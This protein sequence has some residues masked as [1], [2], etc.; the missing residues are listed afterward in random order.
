MTQQHTRVFESVTSFAYHIH[1]LHKEISIPIQRRNANYK[2]Y[3]N[4]SKRARDF[5]IGDYAMIQIHL[6]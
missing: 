4:L 3:A 5:N 6:K 1:K 2:A